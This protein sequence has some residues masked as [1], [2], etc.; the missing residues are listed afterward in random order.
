[1]APRGHGDRTKTAQGSKL[2]RNSTEFYKSNCIRKISSKYSIFH[3]R[4]M[5]SVKRSIHVHCF[6][7]LSQLD[8]CFSLFYSLWRNFLKKICREYVAYMSR[9]VPSRVLRIPILNVTD[10]RPSRVL[11]TSV[12]GDHFTPYMSPI[13]HPHPQR[14]SVHVVLFDL[15]VS[16][17]PN[18]TSL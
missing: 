13:T 9:T 7:L 17:T 8:H 3:Y 6:V 11:P 18:T 14:S 10:V 1:M 4:F 15:N 5:D 16:K 12:T 2:E